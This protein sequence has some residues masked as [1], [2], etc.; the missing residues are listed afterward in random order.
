MVCIYSLPDIVFLLKTVQRFSIEC[1]KTKTKT[2]VI[3]PTNHNR[4]KQ[5]NEPKLSDFKANICH[6]F[7]VQENMSN[8]VMIG[9]G[10]LLIGW[11]SGMNF[12]SQLITERSKAKP[13]QTENY[14]GHSIENCSTGQ[15]RLFTDCYNNHWETCFQLVFQEMLLF[16]IIVM[17]ILSVQDE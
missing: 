2:K 16:L 8:Q 5:Q 4:R 11:E 9:F 14:F 15:K 12:V 13:K 10:L 6:W 1:R 3:N 7:Q 17:V